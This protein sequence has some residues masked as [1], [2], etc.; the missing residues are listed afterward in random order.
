MLEILISILRSIST[1]IIIKRIN[2][3][4]LNIVNSISDKTKRIMIKII[5]RGGVIAIVTIIIEIIEIITIIVT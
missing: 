3:I 1:I 2:I 4:S 5:I